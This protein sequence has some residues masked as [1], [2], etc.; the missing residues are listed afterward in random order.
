MGQAK[1]VQEQK[2]IRLLHEAEEMLDFLPRVWAADKPVHL[3]KIQVKV[4]MAQVH[5]TLAVA[6]A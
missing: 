1:H 6:K 4:A 2:A 5:A 3:M